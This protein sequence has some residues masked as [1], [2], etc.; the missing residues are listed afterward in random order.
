[1][2][3]GSILFNIFFSSVSFLRTHSNPMIIRV[4]T[5]IEII[6]RQVVVFFPNWCYRKFYQEA[7]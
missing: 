5:G 3:A 6:F 2:G 7:Q 1:M 4:V